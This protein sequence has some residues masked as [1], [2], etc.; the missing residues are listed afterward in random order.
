MSRYNELERIFALALEQASAGKGSERHDPQGESFDEQQIVKYGLWQGSNHFCVGQ[1]VKKL[2]ES[3]NLEPEA[4]KR[5]LL[6]AI[7]Y[8][9]GAYRTLERLTTTEDSQ[10]VEACIWAG[11]TITAEDW[12][13]HTWEMYCGKSGEWLPAQS[14]IQGR[15]YRKLG[16]RPTT[17]EVREGSSITVA[18]WESHYW[19][20]WSDIGW[21]PAK[22]LDILRCYRKAGKR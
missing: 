22:G 14:L 4:A 5:E 20:V 21:Q 16:T 12:E 6:G 11:D 9:A 7:V 18:E 10:Q 1:A 17:S 13:T 2:I 3:C 8:A 19:E 15:R